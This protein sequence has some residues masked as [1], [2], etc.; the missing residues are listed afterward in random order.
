MLVAVFAR[1]SLV[2]GRSGD[3]PS[4]LKLDDRPQKEGEKS[5]VMK[6]SREHPWGS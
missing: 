5:R 6:E 3:D 4:M 1:K 2:E